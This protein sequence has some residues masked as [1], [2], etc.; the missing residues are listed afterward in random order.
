MNFYFNTDKSMVKQQLFLGLVWVEHVPQPNLT[1]NA[2]EK[3]EG[4]NF[5]KR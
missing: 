5:S 3:N 4:Y 2:H 1:V